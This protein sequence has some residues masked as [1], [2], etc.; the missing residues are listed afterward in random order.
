VISAPLNVNN[1]LEKI[2]ISRE[3]IKQW[4]LTLHSWRHF[5]NTELQR[6]G[7][8]VSQVQSVTGHKSLRM[9]E[10]YNRPDARN[11]PDVTKAQGA[12]LGGNGHKPNPDGGG[13]F[14]A[15]TLVKQQEQI[16]T[17]LKGA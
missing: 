15:F 17:E 6:Q 13:G 5:L 14:P 4:G 16:Q 3:E 10:W 2:R 12:I 9:T 11:I 8:A 7:L 1:A